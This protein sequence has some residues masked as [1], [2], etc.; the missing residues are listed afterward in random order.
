MYL[1]NIV[2]FLLFW[3]LAIEARAVKAEDIQSLDHDYEGAE[4]ISTERNRR[5]GWI[6][7]AAKAAKA[8]AK[9]AKAVV[10]VAKSKQVRDGVKKTASQARKVYKRV[11]PLFNCNHNCWYN[12]W[13]HRDSRA[14]GAG[15]YHNR[16]SYRFFFGRCYCY[17]KPKC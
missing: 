16:C 17:G 3:F 5:F 13:R 8:A 7:K 2:R 15:K 10:K 1:Q 9:V 11:E 4:P 12:N 6:G 14:R